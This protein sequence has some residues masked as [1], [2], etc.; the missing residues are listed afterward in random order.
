MGVWIVLGD[1]PLA[2]A[3]GLALIAA[4]S[5]ATIVGLLL[6]WLFHRFGADPAYGSGPLA[7][8]IQDILS[9]LVYFTCVAS[10]L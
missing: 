3:L 10:L 7:T 4:G 9:L 2:I 8:V 1:L 5:I 6:P